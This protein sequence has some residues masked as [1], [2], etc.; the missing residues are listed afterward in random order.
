L[1]N[2]KQAACNNLAFYLYLK[3]LDD[4]DNAIKNVCRAAGVDILHGTNSIPTLPTTRTSNNPRPRELIFQFTFDGAPVEGATVAITYSNHF[5]ANCTTDKK[6][7][8]V[9]DLRLA[10]AT[11]VDAEIKANGGFDYHPNLKYWPVPYSGTYVIQ[12]DDYEP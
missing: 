10:S 1:N 6:G 3:L 12:D 5:I 4:A 8:C 11:A 7:Q 2:D 9:E